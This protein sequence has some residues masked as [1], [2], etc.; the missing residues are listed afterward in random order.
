MGFSSYKQEQHV[1]DCVF[2]TY[3]AR[4][5]TDWIISGHNIKLFEQTVAQSA[6]AIYV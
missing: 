6:V 5:K 3:G 1:S 2:H 4:N